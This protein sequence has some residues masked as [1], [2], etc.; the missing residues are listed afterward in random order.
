M[1]ILSKILERSRKM[2]SAY[3]DVDWIYGF[4]KIFYWN[5]FIEMSP[6]ERGTTIVITIFSTLFATGTLLILG[7]VS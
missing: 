1:K 5:G 3:S 4:K 7:V 2:N 6:Q